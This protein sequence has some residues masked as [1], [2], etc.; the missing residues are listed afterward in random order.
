VAALADLVT[1]DLYGD[2]EA[3]ARKRLGGRDPEDWP[4]LASALA[5]GC[6]IWTEERTPSDVALRRGHPIAS[7]FF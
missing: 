5:L 2:Y 4:I 3:E 7:K 6:P 1:A